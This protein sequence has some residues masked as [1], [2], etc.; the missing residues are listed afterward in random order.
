V[1]L[2]T[3][4]LK[5]MK[6]LLLILA[7]AVMSIACSSGADEHDNVISYSV[8]IYDYNITGNPA[9]Y[10]GEAGLMDSVLK[11]IQRADVHFGVKNLVSDSET[12]AD[13]EI[14]AFI[15]QQID[16]F[17]KEAFIE[18]FGNEERFEL[19]FVYGALRYNKKMQRVIMPLKL[20]FSSTEGFTEIDNPD[21]LGLGD[22]SGTLM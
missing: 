13:K 15:R 12:V 14:A 17:P 6:K 5:M 11:M 16:K 8:R 19:E 22:G 10:G 4:K 21:D 9:A 2:E 7:V 1:K 3:L 18:R 20:K